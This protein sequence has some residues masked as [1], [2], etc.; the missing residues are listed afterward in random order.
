MLVDRM[1]EFPLYEVSCTVFFLLPMVF[2]AVLY[3]RM[4]LRIQSSTLE[5]NVEGSVHGE[6]SQA[7]S[8][9]IIPML[10][11]CPTLR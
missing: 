4:G 1:P 8:R 2:I 7:Q 6:T 9:K 3:V 10:S 5:H 11:K